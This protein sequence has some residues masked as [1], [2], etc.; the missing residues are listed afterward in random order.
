LVIKKEEEEK[1]K[2]WGQLEN[3]RTN[4][5]PYKRSAREYNAAQNTHQAQEIRS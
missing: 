1:A 4:A 3:K 5:T 2:F